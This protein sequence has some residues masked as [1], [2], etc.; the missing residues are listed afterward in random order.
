MVVLA[1]AL[2]R[3]LVVLVAVAAAVLRALPIQMYVSATYH[4]SRPRCKPRP[5]SKPR[6]P[7]PRCPRPSPS[8]PPRGSPSPCS[9]LRT[10]RMVH[11]AAK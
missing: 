11:A 8:L 10:R 4:W 6:C 5:R 1:L 7:R 9:A 2:A 3:M